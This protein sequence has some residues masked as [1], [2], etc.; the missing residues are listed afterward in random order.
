MRIFSSVIVTVQNTSAGMLAVDL[1]TAAAKNKMV[2]K[3]SWGEGVVVGSVMQMLTGQ[4]LI[5]NHS[6]SDLQS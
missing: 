5:Y 3:V 6:D 1:L 2:F 4:M